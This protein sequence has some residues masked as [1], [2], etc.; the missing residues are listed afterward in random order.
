MK[1]TLM[2][3]AS[4]TETGG[5]SGFQVLAKSAQKG[6]IDGDIVAVVSNH[7]Y[8][9]VKEKAD[10]LGIPFIHFDGPYTKSAYQDIV[11]QFQP[12]LVCLSGWLKLVKGLDPKT[13]I[14]IHPGPLPRYGGRGMYGQHVHEAVFNDGLQNSA[15]TMHFVTKK[16]DQGPIF[17]QI[18]VDISSATTAHGISRLVNRVEHTW[19]PVITNMV[20]Q[21]D[22][23]W[24][25][26]NPQSLRIPKEYDHL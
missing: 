19:Q 26:S 9:G 7:A 1:K 4:G 2:V 23:S 5:G 10:E 11:S 14:N 8:G 3:F 12:D 17:F 16:Y 21:G 6:I 18:P 25:G 24:D 15:V 20:L 13:T 22:I